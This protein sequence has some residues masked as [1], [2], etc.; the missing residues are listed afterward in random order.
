[1]DWEVG[2]TLQTV[3]RQSGGNDLR[4]ES[5]YSKKMGSLQLEM[6]YQ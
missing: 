1:M 4:E 6:I 3:F 5:G 2:V